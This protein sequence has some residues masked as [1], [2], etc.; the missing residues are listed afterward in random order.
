MNITIRPAKTSDAHAMARVN[1]ESWHTTYRGQ[2]A[3]EILDNMKFEEYVAKWD[4]ILARQS[5]GINFCFVAEN[6]S[7]DVIGYSACGKNSHHKFPYDGE[8]F[9]IYLLKGYQGQGIGKK[10]FLMSVEGFKKRNIFSFLLFVLSSNTGSRKFYESFKP[11]FTANETITIDNGQYCD[12]CY[13][14]SDI[15]LK[16]K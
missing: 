4:N 9:A 15:Q 2:V 10:L 14:W 12:I 7:G 6:D 8:L 3:D 5:D 13:G 1:I 11:D 16:L